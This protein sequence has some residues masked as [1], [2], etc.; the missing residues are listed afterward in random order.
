MVAVLP[1]KTE[2]HAAPWLHLGQSAGAAKAEG[3][4]AAALKAPCASHC[5]GDCPTSQSTSLVKS[6]IVH[7]LR[8]LDELKE[9]G[10]ICEGERMWCRKDV[11]SRMLADGGTR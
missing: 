11:V 1:V 9:D 5:A 7:Q 3:A 10:T 4:G 6:R 2:N 8:I